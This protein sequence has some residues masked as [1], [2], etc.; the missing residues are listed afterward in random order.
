MSFLTFGTISSLNEGRNIKAIDKL[1]K[2]MTRRNCGFVAEKLSIKT[3][4]FP[5]QC[6]VWSLTPKPGILSVIKYVNVI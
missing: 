4:L 2:K 5:A 6:S 3:L 1:N